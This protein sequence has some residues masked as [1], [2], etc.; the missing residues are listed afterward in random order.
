MSSQI[1]RTRA[2][3]PAT[4]WKERNVPS[5]LVLFLTLHYKSTYYAKNVSHATKKMGL[6]KFSS[7][8]KTLIAFKL[9][10]YRVRDTHEQFIK[11]VIHNFGILQNFLHTHEAY[12]A[13]G[14]SH[15]NMKGTERTE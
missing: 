8:I 3:T 11:H 15:T 13:F 7:T 12:K 5:D 9:L 1:K 6:T 14:V 10:S 4:L 2:Q